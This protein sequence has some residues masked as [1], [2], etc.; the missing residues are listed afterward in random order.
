VNSTKRLTEASLLTS[1][2]IVATIIAV[3]IGIGY[4]FYLDFI[5]PVFFAIICLKCGLRYSIL[6][7]CTSILIIF[8]VLG[9][10]GSAIWM[11]QSIIVGILCG[12]LIT[13]PTLMIDDFFYA[14]IIGVILMVFIDIYASKLI[15]YSFM[16]EFERYANML[17]NSKFINI[18]FYMFIALLPMGTIFC[19]YVLTLLFGNKINVLSKISKKKLYMLKNFKVCGR[20]LSCSKRIFF[21]CSVYILIIELLNILG[22]RINQT[23]I[24]TILISSQYICFYFVIRDAIILSQNYIILKYNKTLYLRIFSFITFLSL[25]LFFRITTFILIILNLIIDKKISIRIKQN[26]IIDNYIN[27]LIY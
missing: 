4:A 20:Y 2:F 22:I 14:S 17:S 8:L 19:V 18:V 13:K 9:D 5:V 6:S 7:S 23:Y 21:Y 27:K 1:L 25:M 26:A 3:G 10:I 15:G 16:E 24:R 11:S 12:L